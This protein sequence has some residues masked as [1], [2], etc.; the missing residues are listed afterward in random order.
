MR[1]YLTVLQF[2]LTNYFKNRTY[3]ITTAIIAIVIAIILTMPRFINMADFFGVPTESV[4]TDEKDAVPEE[5][6]EKF[7]LLDTNGYFKNQAILEAAFPETKWIVAKDVEE[8]KA[9]VEKEEAE[10]GF[11]VKSTT[12]FEYYVINKG[13]MDSNSE[14][15]EEVLKTIGQQEY[16][17]KNNLNYEEV[18]AAFNPSINVKEQILGKDTIKNYAYCYTFVIVIFMM[19][20]I[21]GT[22][23]AT[24][25]TAEKSN[26]S[27][28]VLVTSV[29][30]N[31]L[32]FGKVVAGAIAGMFQTTLIIC[33]MLLFYKINRDYWNGALDTFLDIPI[34]SL[35]TF[36]FFGLGGFL[37]YAF[38]YGA[39]GALVSKTED[40]NKSTGGVQM[41][42]M[43]VYFAVLTQLQNADGVVM[44]VASFLPISSYSAMFARVAL[45]KVEL[46][47]VVVSF[48]ILAISVVGMGILGAKIYR[49]GTLR[50]GNPIKVSQA[51]KALRQK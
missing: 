41:V 19:V 34:E 38:C 8:V 44:K 21:Y 42:I 15:F 7:A 22:M 33:E 37:F 10:C 14:T 3:I 31:Y 17:G 40:L 20:M 28:E 49:M 36:G 1:K 18:Q 32:I 9:L 39:L 45:G 47:E 24:S 26:R 43:I 16:C 25:I 51:L 30:S 11:V 23:I 12:E 29:D 27:I 13:M 48:L 50:Y 46:W 5:E 4:D 2:E 35:I 6:Y